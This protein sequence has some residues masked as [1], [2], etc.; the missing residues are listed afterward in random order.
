MC[1]SFQIRNK[2]SYSI[3]LMK[4][5]PESLI[6]IRILSGSQGRFLILFF[7]GLESE[8]RVE[9]QNVLP[10]VVTA[11]GINNNSVCLTVNTDGFLPATIITR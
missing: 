3:W 4:Q 7:A 11:T 10:T 6:S 9:D 2:F 8:R 5:M 1:I